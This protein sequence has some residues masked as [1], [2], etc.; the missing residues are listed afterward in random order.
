MRLALPRTIIVEGLNHRV[1]HVQF[2]TLVLIAKSGDHLFEHIIR[3]VA[4][5]VDDEWVRVYDAAGEQLDL[6]KGHHGPV[7]C[8][9]YTPDGQVAASGSED[10]TIRLWQNTPGTKYGLW[11]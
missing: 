11:A 9:S 3:F 8:V 10:G 7:H 1:A 4:G 2:P 6:H 5:S